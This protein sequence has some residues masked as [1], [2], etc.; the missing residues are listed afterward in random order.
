M[1][2]FCAFSRSS[3]CTLPSH[4]GRD[5]ILRWLLS[6]LSSTISSYHAT[7]SGSKT[8]LGNKERLVEWRLYDGLYAPLLSYNMNLTVLKAFCE[9]WCH[10]TSTFCTKSGDMSISLWDLQIIGELP[11]Y[12]KEIIP[13]ARE[14]LSTGCGNN[15]IPATCSFL[16][17]TFHRLCQDVHGSTYYFWMDMLMILRAANLHTSSQPWQ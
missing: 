15:N 1:C 3:T 16:F 13:S 11:A 7:G 2:I 8:L 5:A 14:L 4:H 12:Y 9:L 10:T 17:S 6:L